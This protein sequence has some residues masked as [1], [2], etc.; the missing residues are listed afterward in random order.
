MVGLP[1]GQERGEAQACK[2][3]SKDACSSD[4][5]HIPALTA[6][7]LHIRAIRRASKASLSGVSSSSN[8]SITAC[9]AACGLAAPTEGVQRG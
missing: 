7:R 4:V 9:K 8:A 1:C 6:A 5:R 2:S 3:N